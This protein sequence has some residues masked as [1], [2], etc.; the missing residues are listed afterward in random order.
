[1]VWHAFQ[2]DPITLIHIIV[3]GV[4]V[5]VFAGNPSPVQM[6]SGMLDALILCCFRPSI[7]SKERAAKASPLTSSHLMR[8]KGESSQNYLTLVPSTAATIE[9]RPQRESLFAEPVITLSGKRVG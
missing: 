5:L 4:H 1:V 6:P 8:N 3:R 2:V 9:V 7:C